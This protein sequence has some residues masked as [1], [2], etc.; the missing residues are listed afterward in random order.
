M[1][2]ELACLFYEVRSRFK[3]MD[4]GD[5]CDACR[6]VSIIADRF[7]YNINDLA[8]ALNYNLPGLPRLSN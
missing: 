1:L 8:Q 3:K 2:L 5:Y 7:G 6:E 4:M